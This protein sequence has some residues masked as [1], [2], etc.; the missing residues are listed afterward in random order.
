MAN[1]ME[2]LFIG[3]AGLMTAQNA[4]NTVANNI[5]NNRVEG[6]VRQEAMQA[7]MGYNFMKNSA[8]GKQMMGLGVSIG[9]ITHT[10]DEFLDK[11]FRTESG[12]QAYYN[13]Y[14]IAINEVE[15]MYQELDGEADRKSVV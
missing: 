1:G 12:R 15:G 11:S 10:R 14:Q 7:D 5:A 13:S 9:E 8:I 3:N 6:Y 2:G 4:L